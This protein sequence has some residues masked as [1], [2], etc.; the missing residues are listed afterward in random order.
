MKERL[1][2]LTDIVRGL[3]TD[4]IESMVRLMLYS[5]VIDVEGLI[6]ATSCFCKNKGK[7]KNKKLIIDVINAY[8]QV[9]V[10]LDKHEEGYP[11]SAYLRSITTCGISKYG[12]E[13]GNGWGEEWMNDNPGV[14]LIIDAAD[15]E[16]DRPLWVA[17]WGG[18][19]TLA[20]AVWKVWK[21]RSEEAFN[22]FISKLRIY[23]ISDQDNGGIWL[24][25]QFGNKL[26][27]IASPSPGDW[28]GGKF[29]C[30]AT[31]PG[32]A[33][34]KVAHGSENGIDGGGFKG[35]DYS[36]VGKKWLKK[37][38]RSHGPLG[39][40]YPNLFVIMEGDTPTYLYLIPNGLGSP[41]H[42]N[43]GSWGGR[44]EFYKPDP[45]YTGTEEKYP[46]WTN[47]SDKVLGNNGEWYNSPQAT[48]WRWREAFQNDF[49]ARMDWTITDKYSEANHPPIVKLN[50]E[51][52]LTVTE[53][54]YVNLSAEGTYDPDGDEL[55]YS[56]IYYREAGTY[57]SNITIDNVNGIKA[58]F[59][60]PA[61]SGDSE[62]YKIHII[63]E[64]KDNGEPVLTRYQRVIVTVLRK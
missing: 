2:V 37:H 43:Y 48:I 7:E 27:Y 47:A 60:A 35:A 46:F 11:D 20:H 9:K 18:A 12:K 25:K 57:A 30:H 63:L 34:D 53:G 62:E 24:R 44:Y 19:N 32:I 1:I 55:T 40:K 58:G 22:K 38:I 29:Y 15:K 54:E 39:K 45:E 21:T 64:V 4:D 50:H 42:P 5:N 28:K 41:E 36:L 51:N 23:G 56:W 13:E 61:V 3:E 17:L 14:N 8:E 52:E 16:D 59:T 26:F 31:W 33:A 6:A 49:A 10:N